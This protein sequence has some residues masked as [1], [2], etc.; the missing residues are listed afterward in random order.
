MNGS[1]EIFWR[2]AACLRVQSLDY[3]VALDWII[4]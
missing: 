3:V 1:D 2:P 4:S